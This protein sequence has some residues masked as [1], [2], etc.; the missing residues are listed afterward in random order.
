MNFRTFRAVT[1]YLPQPT[2]DPSASHGPRVFLTVMRSGLWSA[3]A[4]KWSGAV[5]GALTLKVREFALLV[6]SEDL[7]ESRIRLC[8]VGFQLRGQLADGA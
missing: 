7:I 2:Q 8:M 1:V 6:Q 5:R 3:A 4:M